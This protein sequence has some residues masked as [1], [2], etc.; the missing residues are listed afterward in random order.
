MKARRNVLAEPPGTDEQSAWR[1]MLG[2]IAPP[3]ALETPT[4]PAQRGRGWDKAHPPKHYRGV[5]A[6][7]RRAVVDI[8]QENNVPADEVA[9]A[10]LEYGLQCLQQKRLALNVQPK[11]QRMTLYPVTG[12]GWAESG[13]GWTP[14]TKRTSAN[15]RRKSSTWQEIAHYRIPDELHSQVK[16]LAGGVLPIGEVVTVLLKNGIEAYR[17]GVLVLIPSPRRQATVGWSKWAGEEK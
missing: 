9:R 17:S 6:E 4:P 3:E 5:P 1:Q 8:A 12:T 15:G 14:K 11:A 7:I 10:F 13:D 2:Q 16:N